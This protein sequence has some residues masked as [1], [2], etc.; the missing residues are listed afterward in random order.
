[1]STI[2]IGDVKRAEVKKMK[3]WPHI[4]L[5]A[6][7]DYN[8]TIQETG[9]WTTWCWAY[10]SPWHLHT[11]IH[12]FGPGG[13]KSR[14]ICEKGTS[15]I[16]FPPLHVFVSERQASSLVFHSIVCILGLVL[17]Y[18]YISHVC[19]VGDKLFVNSQVCYQWSFLPQLFYPMLNNIDFVSLFSKYFYHLGC[20]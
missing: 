16:P 5:N 9:P 19:K 6:T 4:M 8:R 13:R 7:P 12:P 3:I 11:C 2:Y 18:N 15:P 17:V 10:H 1:M 20:L 14:L